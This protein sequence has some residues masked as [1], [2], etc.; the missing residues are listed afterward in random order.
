MAVVAEAA[1]VV[2]IGS[3]F[4]GAATAYHLTARGMR[5][6]VVLEA[7]PR[8]GMH[9]SGKNA[10]ICFQLIADEAEARL[11]IEGTEISASPPEDLSDRPLLARRGS[12]FLAG[13]DN[14]AV[15]DAVLARIAPWLDRLSADARNA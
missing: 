3:G 9:A 6:V 1:E 11:A 13:A 14:R 12:L 2:I 8:A 7:E 15:L 4:A 5:D 10:A